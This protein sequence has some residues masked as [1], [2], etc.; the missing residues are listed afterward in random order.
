MREAR[1]SDETLREGPEGGGDYPIVEADRAEEEMAPV[2][3][4]FFM[5]IF[6]LL[7]IGLWATVFWLLLSR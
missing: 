4:L 5:V 6:L 3:T 7:M 1:V 2:G